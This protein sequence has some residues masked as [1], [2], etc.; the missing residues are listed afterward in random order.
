MTVAA[1]SRS[2]PAS[3]SVALEPGGLGA[4]EP[5]G[6]L[7]QAAAAVRVVEAR[8]ARRTALSS[9]GVQRRDRPCR[10]AGPAPEGLG[11]A[12]GLERVSLADMGS[13]RV[14][15]RDMLRLR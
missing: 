5:I 12:T 9:D 13:D 8:R 10:P 14:A 2:M 11:Y 4:A 1:W 3:V 15:A 7:D 6:E